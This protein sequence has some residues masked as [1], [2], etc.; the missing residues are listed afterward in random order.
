MNHEKKQLFS[1]LFLHQWSKMHLF[2]TAIYTLET[3]T[4]LLLITCHLPDFFS[5][6]KRQ[7]RELIN[8]TLLF[9]I[10]LKWYLV[11]Y[12]VKQ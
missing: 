7:I 5:S 6:L 10:C 1:E 3:V 8:T 2:L 9:S 12:I 4:G 11:E